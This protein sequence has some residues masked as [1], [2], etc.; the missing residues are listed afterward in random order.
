MRDRLL[1]DIPVVEHQL[2]LAGV[3]TAV[4]AGGSGPDLVLLHGPGATGL[5]WMRV[6]PDLM[7]TNRVLVPD[8]P[9]Q[10][11][12]Q[13]IDGPLSE[14]RVIDWL[15]ALIDRTCASPPALAGYA[16]GGRSRPGSRPSRAIG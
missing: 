6:L 1:K 7:T 8:L 9:G 3:S 5:H 2:E 11:S 15:S 16:L 4:L 14:E 12:S 13:V 10:G